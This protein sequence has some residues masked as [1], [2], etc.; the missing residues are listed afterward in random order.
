MLERRAKFMKKWK[1]VWN[2]GPT[3][4]SRWHLTVNDYD[5]AQ[6]LISSLFE[7]TLVA[8][9]DLSNVPIE[10]KFVTSA[11]AEVN[12]LGFRTG[13]HR[14]TGITSDDR[15]AELIDEIAESD[16]SDKDVPFDFIITTL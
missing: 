9:V 4:C 15:V 16:V 7:K 10:R 6:N 14:L 13:I 8:E 2:V 11:T 3:G 5:S 12:N 1:N